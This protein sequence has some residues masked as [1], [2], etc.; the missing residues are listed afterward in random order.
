M[1]RACNA[2]SQEESQRLLQMEEALH[3]RVIAQNEAIEKISRAVRRARAGLKDPRRPIGSF[4]FL[5]PTGVGKTELARALAE[6]MFDSEDA[7]IRLDMSEVMERHTTAR[8]VGSPP[9]YVGY[10]EGGQ[11][12]E[13]IRRRPCSVVLFD[14]IE[15]AHPEVFNMLLQILEDGRLADAKGKQVNF[16]NT[17]VIMTSNIGVMNLQQATTS[18]GFQ[19]SMPSTSQEEKEHGKMREKIMDELK[20]TFRP[21]FLNRVDAVVV[22]KA[23]SPAEMRQIVD[24][25]VIKVAQRLEEH[26]M[27]LEVTTDAKDYLA[28]EGYDK[29]YGARPLRRVIQRL[30]EDPLSETLLTTKFSAGDSVLVELV[31]DQITLTPVQ[32]Q[33]EP[34]AEKPEKP[35]KP[36]IEPVAG[37]G[38]GE[39]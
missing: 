6:F 16:A 15:K 11:L 39:G 32:K 36:L 12:T 19:P 38:K 31:D 29:I 37:K 28:K 20:K 9:G 23:L 18:M 5:G 26:E 8:L 17:I 1:T 14:E 25:L 34:K 27:K 33:R 4:I 21:E 7:L 3:A 24:L 2:S 13:A 35:E 22:F 30:I 10:D